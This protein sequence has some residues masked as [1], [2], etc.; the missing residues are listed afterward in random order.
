MQKLQKT[1][2]FF[3]PELKESDFPAKWD[4]ELAP[5][6][7]L[8]S[9]CKTIFWEPKG[10]GEQILSYKLQ[11]LFTIILLF[12]TIVVFKFQ[13]SYT[14][15]KE[16]VSFFVKCSIACLYSS[17]FIIII[18]PWRGP[19]YLSMMHKNPLQHVH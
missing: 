1:F 17:V 10:M 16:Q 9:E 7:E 18:C 13:S 19:L 4:N 2:L 15:H 14:S 12:S 6:S 3:F 8:S 11:E 5:V